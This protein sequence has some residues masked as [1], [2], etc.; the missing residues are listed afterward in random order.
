MVVFVVDNDKFIMDE[1]CDLLIDFVD[2]FFDIYFQELCNVMLFLD[3]EKVG[4]GV[5][6]FCV[7]GWEKNFVLEEVVDRLL[8]GEV[9]DVLLFNWLS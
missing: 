1:V 7:C 3:W 4:F 8:L 9:L 6:I 5:Y 2:Y